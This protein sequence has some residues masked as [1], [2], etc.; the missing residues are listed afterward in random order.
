MTK[1]VSL[2]PE[3]DPSE[4]TKHKPTDY[5]VRFVFGAAISLVAGVIGLKFGPVV[6]GVLLGFPA[7]LPASLTLIEKKEGKEEASIDSLGAMAMVAFAVVVTLWV[8]SW[9]VVPSLVVAMIVWFVVAG[10]LY[11]LVAAVYRREPAPP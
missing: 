3:V 1:G 2:V 10:A 5:L 8:T 7:I 4:V 11:F 9:G 6:G